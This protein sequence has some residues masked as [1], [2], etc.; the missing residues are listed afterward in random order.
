MS[1]VDLDYISINEKLYLPRVQLAPDQKINL[2]QSHADKICVRLLC[3]KRIKFKYQEPANLCCVSPPKFDFY[4]KVI[5]H[6]HGGGFISLSSRSSQTFTRRWATELQVPVF[7]VDYRL[8]PEEV[9]PS[10][11]ED[12]Y[13]AYL[14]ITQNLSHHMNI[15]PKKIMLVGEGSGGNLVI[16]LVGLLLKNKKQLPST[17]VLM[18]PEADLREDFSPSRLHALDNCQ[19]FPSLMMLCHRIYCGEEIDNPWASPILLTEEAVN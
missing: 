9:F 10:A 14:F 5:I 7:S 15:K 18:Y 11:L 3:D 4:E 13:S 19:I 8:G 12:C 6:F 16:A 1:S 17:I 2:F